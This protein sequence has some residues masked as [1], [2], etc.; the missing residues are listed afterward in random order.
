ML[1]ADDGSRFSVNDAII[2]P[3]PWA[4][5][6][7]FKF[8][9]CAMDIPGVA[10]HKLNAQLFETYAPIEK[11]NPAGSHDAPAGLAAPHFSGLAAIEMEY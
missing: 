11:T 2:A 7:E 1:G 6:V 5:T 8:A 3:G 9:V 10:L 4:L